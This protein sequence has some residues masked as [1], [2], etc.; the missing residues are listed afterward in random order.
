MSAQSIGA[1]IKEKRE[2]QERERVLEQ[3]YQEFRIPKE[4]VTDSFLYVEKGV[5]C[6]NDAIRIRRKMLG[7]DLKELCEG[8]AM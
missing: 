8:S 1:F 4:T 6:I 3:S 5:S 2:N 7:M